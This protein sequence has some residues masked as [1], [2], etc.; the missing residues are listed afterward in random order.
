MKSTTDCEDMQDTI[1]VAPL[2]GAWIEIGI[3]QVCVFDA[4]DVAPLEGAWIE[5]SPAKQ[6]T[7]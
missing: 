6:T 7:R 1:S 3:D 4:I 2:E 5:I